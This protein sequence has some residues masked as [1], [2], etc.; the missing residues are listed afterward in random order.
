MPFSTIPS[1]ASLKPSP[2]KVDI[3]DAELEDLKH[4]VQTAR[5]GPKTWENSVTDVK[6]LTSFGIQR[7]WLAK[8]KEEWGGR[9]NWRKAEERINRLPNY[10]VE[11]ED[12]GFKFEV[13]FAALLSKRKDAVPLLFLHG[14]PGSFL[15]FLGRSST[16]RKEWYGDT[17]AAS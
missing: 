9:Y 4:L 13:H 1:N 15:E 14:W 17:R 16:V 12:S 5:I 8:L 7:D 3:P 6:S 2:F 10:K 11:I